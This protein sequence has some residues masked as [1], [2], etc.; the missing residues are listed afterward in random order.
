MN[1]DEQDSKIT[2][3]N[4][5][6]D[7]GMDVLFLITYIQIYLYVILNLKKFPCFTFSP[8]LFVKYFYRIQCNFICIFL[9]PM[10]FC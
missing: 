9:F 8:M 7:S 4:G 3:I 6:A 1:Q 2:L 5:D 10:L